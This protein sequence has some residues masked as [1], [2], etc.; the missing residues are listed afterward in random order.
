MEVVA[1]HVGASISDVAAQL[2]AS[3]TR[4]HDR[5]LLLGTIASTRRSTVF[6]AVDQLLAREVALEV[7]HDSEDQTTWR[8]LAE[9]QAMTQCDHAN[10]VRVYE[11]GDLAT[12]GAS[13]PGDRPV[14][15]VAMVATACRA[16][17]ISEASMVSRRCS[18]LK[19]A[20]API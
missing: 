3:N 11:V 19:A 9:V 17:V 20:E 7:L 15:M 6:A 16:R 8:L 1:G 5:Y 14:A 18:A 4:A 10:I 2:F 12:R 13:L